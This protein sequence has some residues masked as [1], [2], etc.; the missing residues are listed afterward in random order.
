MKRAVP[1]P[2]WAWQRMLSGQLLGL[3]D[4]KP[5]ITSHL[6]TPFRRVIGP[7]YADGA[8]PRR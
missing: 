8:R 1:V 5:L 6:V 2:V 4:P 3:I 7:A